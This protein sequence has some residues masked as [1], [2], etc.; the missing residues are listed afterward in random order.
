MRET[1]KG[2]T[3]SGEKFSK[4]NEAARLAQL[5]RINAMSPLQRMALA[6]ELGRRRRQLDRLR[7]ASNK[8]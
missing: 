8:R 5:E 6:L 1:S 7:P 4:S 2:P 3:L